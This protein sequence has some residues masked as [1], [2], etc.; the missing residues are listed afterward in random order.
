LPAIPRRH[1]T[2]EKILDGELSAFLD[3]SRATQALN[4]WSIRKGKKMRSFLVKSVLSAAFGSAVIFGGVLPAQASVAQAAPASAVSAVHLSPAAAINYV[5]SG[6]NYPKTAQGLKACDAEGTA[7][8]RGGAAGY[9]CDYEP[10][11][12]RW[13]LWIG[14]YN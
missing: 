14:E 2:G 10:N 4:S 11:P 6:H 8:V 7:Y 12:N 1:G 3:T 13:N 5:Y 9:Y